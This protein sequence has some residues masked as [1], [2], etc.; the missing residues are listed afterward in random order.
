MN[1][2]FVT[3]L[4]GYGAFAAFQA[5]A[6]APGESRAAKVPSAAKEADAAFSVTPD[7]NAVLPGTG[8][9]EERFDAFARQTGIRFGEPDASGRVFYTAAVDVNA[10]PSES[11]FVTERLS[12]FMRAK[13]DAVAQ[14]IR[15]M[16]GLHPGEPAKV[17]ESKRGLCV[18]QT[19]EGK[20][21]EGAARIGVI[22]RYDPVVDAL[23]R[24]VADGRDATRAP[25]SQGLPARAFLPSD[26]AALVQSFGS[27]F[28]YNER[29][30]PSLVV[31]GQWPAGDGEK[32]PRRLLR[33]REDAMNKA[34]NIALAFLDGFLA[35]RGILLDGMDLFRQ[36]ELLFREVVKHPSG[37]AVAVCAY[38]WRFPVTEK[39][40]TKEAVPPSFVPQ[41]K[42]VFSGGLSI[43]YDF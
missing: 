3:F 39:V 2:I 28:F 41:K 37:T 33:L 21:A 4:A 19:L 16:N 20:S 24:D 25:V 34:G 12:S 11:S 5:M 31:F 40:E 42:G 23:V 27:R 43:D 15:R 32:D 35:E 8:T 22:L 10:E 14:H 36:S 13:G 9:L 38:S 29:G 30:I 26:T 18:T 1:M 17:A 6:Q 7:F